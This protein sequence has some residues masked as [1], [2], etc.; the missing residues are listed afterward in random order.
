LV[1]EDIKTDASVAVD[2][3]VVDFCSEVDLTIRESGKIK[4]SISSKKSAKSAAKNPGRFQQ[5][6]LGA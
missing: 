1:F 4:V 2:V 3:G 5:V 6:P